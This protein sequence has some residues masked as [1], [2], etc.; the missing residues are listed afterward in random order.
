MKALGS[1]GAVPVVAAQSDGR[2]DGLV[3]YVVEVQML[4][5]VDLAAA[6]PADVAVGHKPD[7]GPEALCA[8]EACAYVDAGGAAQRPLALAVDAARN[9][10]TVVIE[11]LG[12]AY[13][14][15]AKRAILDAAQGVERRHVA[16]PVGTARLAAAP[17]RGVELVRV[18]LLGPYQPPP[19]V[20]AARV[21]GLGLGE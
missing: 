21:A 7:G 20:G 17:R 13:A 1:M 8:V 9:A 19:L 6:G 10:R 16:H 2:M 15:E 4:H 18:E 14:V 3:G 5:D 12:R 11:A